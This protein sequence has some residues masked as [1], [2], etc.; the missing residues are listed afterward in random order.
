MIL[1]EDDFRH[2][3]SVGEV[4]RKAAEAKHK[5]LCPLLETGSEH[6]GT[7]TDSVTGK[8][9]QFDYRFEILRTDDGLGMND[10][11]RSLLL[12]VECKNL[13]DLSPLVVCGVPRATTEARHYFI[14]SV[15]NQFA[16]DIASSVEAGHC[17]SAFYSRG[18]F[19]GKSA[20]R[21]KDNGKGLT[22]DRQQD[23]YDKMVASGSISRRTCT[24]GYAC[25][26]QDSKE[27]E[28]SP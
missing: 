1:D 26:S 17:G 10:C 12:A 6:G 2:E 7:Y 18:D 21:L 27:G 16:Q 23:G 3:L 15:K 13:N 5:S 14:D 11:V 22:I 24:P 20:M 19:V 9:R 4:F 8:P 25:S 28:C